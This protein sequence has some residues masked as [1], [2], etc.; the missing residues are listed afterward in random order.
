MNEPVPAA[1]PRAFPRVPL[2]LAIAGTALWAAGATVGLNG[3]SQAAVFLRVTALALFAVATA[4]RSSLLSWT[5]L[6]MLGGIELGLDAPGVA[7]QSRFLGDLFLRLIRMII[8]PLLFATITTGIA[9]HGQL[10]SIGRVAVKALVYFEIVTTLGL[11]IGVVA[12]YLSGAGWGIALPASQTLIPG[13]QA[14]QTWQQIV[15]NI[16]P[17]NIAQAVA[18][19]Q[20]LQVA[21]FS[22]LF[23]TALALLP[24]GKRAPLLTS[25]SIARRHHVPT[26]ADRDAHGSRCSGSSPGLHRWR[27]GPAR[28]ASSG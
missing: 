26:Y 18:Q 20:I 25:S 10:R 2:I 13:A 14:I 24:E 4:L 28:H 1:K 11:I 27:H 3:T 23:A 12:M 6:A 17:E 7:V 5:L 21:V 9:G 16:F 22:V 19:N 15:L 8:S